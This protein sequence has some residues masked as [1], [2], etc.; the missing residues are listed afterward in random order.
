[1]ESGL[2]STSIRAQEKLTVVGGALSY[3][4]GK[5][6]V[7]LK[8]GGE[9]VAEKV[10]FLLGMFCNQYTGAR[11]SEGL[12]V[13]EGAPPSMINTPSDSMYRCTNRLADTLRVGT[14]DRSILDTPK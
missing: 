8:L 1:M 4:D 10:R 7:W 12:Q 2:D 14:V 6:R 9:K 5:L 11:G 13:A 3:V